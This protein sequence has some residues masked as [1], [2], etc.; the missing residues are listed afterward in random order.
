M[1]RLVILVII[2]STLFA[3]GYLGV[4][5]SILRLI[6]GDLSHV[7]TGPVFS[8][9]SIALGIA[10]LKCCRRQYL[11]TTPKIIGALMLLFAAVDLADQIEHLLLGNARINIVAFVIVVLFTA[12][13]FALLRRSHRK[14]AK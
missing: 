14:D 11:L 2:G 9:G 6:R 1:I 5:M 3:I 7:L 12:G 8:L 10:I 4:V 13:G